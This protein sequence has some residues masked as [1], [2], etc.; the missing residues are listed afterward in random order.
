M[1]STA[2][3]HAPIVR[4]PYR[5]N[6]VG[7]VMNSIRESSLASSRMNISPIDTWKKHSTSSRTFS[8]DSLEKVSVSKRVML[9]V[10]RT[11]SKSF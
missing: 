3:I 9:L 8:R 10:M 11:A 5:L 7:S 6:H 1:E 2:T 4:E